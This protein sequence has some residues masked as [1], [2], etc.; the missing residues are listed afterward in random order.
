MNVTDGDSSADSRHAISA[1][2]YWIIRGNV[3]F[4]RREFGRR[5]LA[6]RIGAE[7]S[8][9]DLAVA[10]VASGGRYALCVVVTDRVGDDV[11]FVP[12]VDGMHPHEAA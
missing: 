7:I 6:P 8:S 4:V 2:L 1:D 12:L 9:I 10:T 3:R 5:E 11:R